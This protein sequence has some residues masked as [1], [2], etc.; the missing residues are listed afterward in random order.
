MQTKLE[1]GLQGLI[2]KLND[3]DEI[4]IAKRL[5]GDAVKS[6]ENKKRR[7]RI[8]EAIKEGYSTI[9]QIS[10]HTGLSYDCVRNK[11]NI[12]AQQK[13]ITERLYKPLHLPGRPQ[14]LFSIPE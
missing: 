10:E 14:R 3:K 11:V 5:Y 2:K 12:L 6:L 1:K 13:K 7:N 8:L 9:S 4:V